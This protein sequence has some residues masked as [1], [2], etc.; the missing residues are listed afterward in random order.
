MVGR[1]IPSIV[2]ARQFNLEFLVPAHLRGMPLLED[3]KGRSNVTEPGC[4]LHRE[5]ERL[6]YFFTQY[7]PRWKSPSY[8]MSIIRN[9]LH[10]TRKDK[11]PSKYHITEDL[12]RF[13]A[14][15]KTLNTVFE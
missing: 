1:A 13:T 14:P 5:P 7:M 9:S 15:K 11:G 10:F 6:A 3:T 8:L 4:L 2:S 12:I